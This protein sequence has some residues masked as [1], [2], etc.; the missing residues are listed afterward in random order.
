MCKACES[1]QRA[2]EEQAKHDK[3]AR[4]AGK[5]PDYAR[6]WQVDSRSVTE[7]T[8]QAKKTASEKTPLQRMQDAVAALDEAGTRTLEPRLPGD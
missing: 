8:E 3:A 6:V 2:Q 4:E 5:N 7:L 1:L